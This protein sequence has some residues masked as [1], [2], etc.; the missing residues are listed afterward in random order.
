[1]NINVGNTDRILRI[2]AG[3]VLI[4]LFF[5]LDGPWRYIGLLGLVALGTAFMRSCPLYS[6][7]RISTRGKSAVTR[8]AA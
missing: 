6:V 2:V 5:I 4:A 3:I 1:M 8:D 7:L